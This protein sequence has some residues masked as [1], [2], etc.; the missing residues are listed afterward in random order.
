M[1]EDFQGTVDYGSEFHVEAQ[2]HDIDLHAD[3]Y[4]ENLK[5]NEADF[6]QRKKLARGLFGGKYPIG[7][8]GERPSERHPRLSPI[9]KVLLTS[10][11]RKY[12]AD[13]QHRDQLQNP[14]N[15]QLP[16]SSI[17]KI[18]ESMIEKASR[19]FVFDGKDYARP[20][21][22]SLTDNQISE[23]VLNRIGLA[24]AVLARDIAQRGETA[25]KIGSS[26]KFDDI[27]DELILAEIPYPPRQIAELSDAI[28]HQLANQKILNALS[29]AWGSIALDHDGSPRMHIAIGRADD[30]PPSRATSRKIRI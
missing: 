11:L 15:F 17:S 10:I 29:G 26:S 21:Q 22:A 8:H 19:M 27:I 6:P 4:F 24:L 14:L 7:K 5:S 1:I 16:P 13:A 20:F 2:H 30:A 18:R 28:F 3:E 23:L 9:E 12:S 25:V